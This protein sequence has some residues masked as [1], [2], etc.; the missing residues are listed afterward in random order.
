MFVGVGAA[1]VRN[2]FE[3][4]RKHK[5][6]IIFI[7]EIDAVATD[8][9]VSN[10]S[11]SEKESTL[12][13]L[14]SEMDGFQD[15][16]DVIIIAGT[17][18]FNYLDKAILRPGR[19]DRH[20]FVGPP[21]IEGRQELFKYYM[22]PLNLSPSLSSD[23]VAK[24]LAKKNPGFTG[25]SIANMCNEAAIIATRE[26]A[27]YINLTHFDKAEDRIRVGAKT[28]KVLSASD[29]HVVSV[30]EA[31][32]AIIGWNLATISPLTKVTIVPRGFALGFAQ[33]EPRE[34]NF[35]SQQQVFEILNF[36]VDYFSYMN[37]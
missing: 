34:Y 16:K 9:S 15:N 32:H 21:D 4:A 20:I 28:G 5:P 33:Y 26:N 13:Q 2:L 27:D 8:R 36:I 30:H 25:A 11:Y 23:E 1:R 19:F 14:L 3:T 17:N 22:K 24:I 31:G 18:K 37:N 12:N 29:R 6:A 7:D 35:M 10:F